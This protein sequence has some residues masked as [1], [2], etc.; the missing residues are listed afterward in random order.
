MFSKLKKEFGISITAM[1]IVV[2]LASGSAKA[3]EAD[4]NND[5]IVS[6]ELPLEAM[7]FRYN[8]LDGSIWEV[9]TAEKS[10]QTHDFIAT[11]G[12]YKFTAHVLFRIW[13]ASAGAPADEK[14]YDLFVIVDRHEADGT[15]TT[16]IQ[17]TEINV[18]A[19]GKVNKIVAD[20]SFNSGNNMFQTRVDLTK[21]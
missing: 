17:N 21:N 11:C 10:I 12:D 13:P 7:S 3:Q 2:A 1:T 4:A 19:G 16:S 18:A 15:I 5:D 6:Q 9:C 20:V 14:T 8:S